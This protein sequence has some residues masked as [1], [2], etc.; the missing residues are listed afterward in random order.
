MNLK[1]SC[2]ANSKFSLKCIN[3]VFRLQR[4]YNLPIHE[5]RLTHLAVGLV[6]VLQGGNNMYTSI[7]VKI[8]AAHYS[9]TFKYMSYF[10]YVFS[11]GNR[12]L[13]YF[14]LMPTFYFA[15]QHPLPF[16]SFIQHKLN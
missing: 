11:K 4:Y 15:L 6:Y 16:L 14:K 12:C 7:V 8:A 2:G 9:N 5:V 3:F 13:T 1:Y 10:K